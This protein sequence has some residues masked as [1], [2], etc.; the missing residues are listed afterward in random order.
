VPVVSTMAGGASDGI[1]TNA[2]GM[3]TYGV[4]GIALES[5]DVRAHGK[6]ERLPV[7]SYD[8]GIDFYYDFL[9]TLT[10]TH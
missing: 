1:Y 5:D 2:A 7:I 9:K 8:R 3:P 4:S 10:T 6:D